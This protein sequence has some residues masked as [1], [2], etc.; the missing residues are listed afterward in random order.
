MNFMTKSLVEQDSDEQS[1]EFKPK[2]DRK[3]KQILNNGK[4]VKVNN[5]ADRYGL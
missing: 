1:F 3:I 5:F 2:Y 4:F